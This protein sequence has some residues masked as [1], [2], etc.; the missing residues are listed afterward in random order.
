[1]SGET[2]R[3]YDGSVNFGEVDLERDA[4]L[5][6]VLTRCHELLCAGGRLEGVHV[7]ELPLGVVLEPRLPPRRPED[8][9]VPERGAGLLASE[10]GVLLVTIRVRPRLVHD[11]CSD[12]GFS[13]VDAASL[14]RR[15][16][17]RQK[18]NHMRNPG[19]GVTRVSILWIILIV[20]LVLL[21]LG[22]F[23]RGRW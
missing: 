11:E 3:G 16:G 8:P 2:G 20:V 12:H 21:L 7:R 17:K 13:F 23:S 1:M 4:H 14:P 19:K 18:W 6:P 5:H 10:L 22:F 15:F 9:P